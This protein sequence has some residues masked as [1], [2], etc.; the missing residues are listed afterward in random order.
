MLSEMPIT[1]IVSTE[2]YRNLFAYLLCLLGFSAYFTVSFCNTQGIATFIQPCFG[3]CASAI[4]DGKRWLP[5][6]NQWLFF[7]K[8]WMDTAL[9][10]WSS[11]PFFLCDFD[12]KYFCAGLEMESDVPFSSRTL[13]S[14]SDISALRSKSY[15]S[16]SPESLPA[17]LERAIWR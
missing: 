14:V 13:H 15:H 3:I 12:M 4:L 6:R 9:C 16:R 5:R 17:R 11:K 2:T 10:W 7:S 1:F 8:T